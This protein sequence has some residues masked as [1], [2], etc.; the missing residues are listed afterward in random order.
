MAIV[1]QRI[2][3]FPPQTTPLFHG[4]VQTMVCL[5]P[6]WQEACRWGRG[7]AYYYKIP[8]IWFQGENNCSCARWEGNRD[9]GVLDW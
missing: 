9:L 2:G 3:T 8:A 5:V 7:M 4:W 1:G 6:V